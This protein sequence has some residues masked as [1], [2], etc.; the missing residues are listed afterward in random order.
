MTKIDALAEQ[1]SFLLKKQQEVQEFFKKEFKSLYD[2]LGA[3]QEKSE[4]ANSGEELTSF[5]NVL[6]MLSTYEKDS[7]DTLDQDIEFLSEQLVA[8]NQ[9]AQVEDEEKSEELIKMLLDDGYELTDTN[10]F[11]ADVEQE[12]EQAKSSFKAMVDDVKA[13]LLEEGIGELELLLEAHKAEMERQENEKEENGENGVE[14][15]AC[16]SSCHSCSGCNLFEEFELA[17]DEEK[18]LE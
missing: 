6:T 18:D 10:R 12:A 17:S 7:I 4:K 13:T 14:E 15:S 2:L 5:Q 11:K 16:G 3:E 1:T 8:I 9:I